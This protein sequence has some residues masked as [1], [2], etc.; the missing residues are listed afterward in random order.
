[1]IIKFIKTKQKL[2]SIKTQLASKPSIRKKENVSE[3][4]QTAGL[5]STQMVLL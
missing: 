3:V 4:K 5:V 2:L 1:M